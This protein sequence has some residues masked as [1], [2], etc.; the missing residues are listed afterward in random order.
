MNDSF[1]SNVVANVDEEACRNVEETRNETGERIRSAQE[2]QKA[3]FD[4]KRKKSHV[5]G[6]GT[7]FLYVEQ[8]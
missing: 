6:L 4:A 7:L 5:Y 1:L 8:T 2:K 3:Y